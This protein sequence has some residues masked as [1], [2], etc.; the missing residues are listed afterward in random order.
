MPLQRNGKYG[1]VTHGAGKQKKMA[2]LSPAL[3]SRSGAAPSAPG[4]DEFKRPG[5]RRLG[6]RLHGGRASRHHQQHDAL[7]GRATATAHPA[8]AGRLAAG[9]LGLAGAPRARNGPGRRPPRA[10]ATAASPSKQRP[11]RRRR[12]WCRRNLNGAVCY[13]AWS[14]PKLCAAPLER[15]R[16]N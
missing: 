6:A 3:H 4:R 14:F 15:R 11:R 16:A 2:C 5:S 10:A 9:A 13:G 8:A 1:I 12:W 7:C